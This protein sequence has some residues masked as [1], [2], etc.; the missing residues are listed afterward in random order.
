MGVVLDLVHSFPFIND[1]YM[2]FLPETL[3]N[4]YTTILDNPVDL[5]HERSMIIGN[6]IKAELIKEENKPSVLRV[7]VVLYKDILEQNWIKDISKTGWSMECLYS[8]YAFSINGKIFKKEDYPEFMERLDDWRS[9]VPVY[10]SVGNRVSLIL[11][12][13]D[14]EIEFNGCGLI[15]WG[16]QADPFANTLLSVANKNKGVDKMEKTYTDAEVTLKVQAAEAAMKEVVKKEYEPKLEEVKASLAAKDE[17]ITTLKAEN[18]EL[19]TKCATASE[20][21]AGYVVKE[22]KAALASKGYPEEML[23]KKED[24]L[25]TA[26]EEDFNGFVEEFEALAKVLK[27]VQSAT[28]SRNTGAFNFLNL[29]HNSQS[30]TNDD[31]S[32]V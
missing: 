27:P 7:C 30:N 28:A 18:D 3:E 19:K 14:G 31:L 26:S 12:G 21:I 17:E 29:T 6:V 13:I 11:G 23:G 32:L 25:K 5:E 2:G 22:R 20:I 4:S 9:G 16:N 8:D 15:N 10:D 1:N 24:F